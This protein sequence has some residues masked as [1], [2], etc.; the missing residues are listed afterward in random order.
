MKVRASVLLLRQCMHAG[1][2]ARVCAGATAAR[3]RMHACM[4]TRVC[5]CMH[6]RVQMYARMCA[7]A[8]AARRRSL[9]RAGHQWPAG[10]DRAAGRWRWIG[11]GWWSGGGPQRGNGRIDAGVAGEG[12]SDGTPRKRSGGGCG[13]RGGGA[14]AGSP[15]SHGG[16]CELRRRKIAGEDGEGARAFKRLDV[17]GW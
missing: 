17:Q 7:G 11:W 14:S 4:D 16:R 3:C 13:Q 5:A 12:R 1:V 10:L 9:E 15:R 2:W 8:T 6:M